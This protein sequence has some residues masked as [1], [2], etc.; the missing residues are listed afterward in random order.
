MKGLIKGSLLRESALRMRWLEELVLERFYLLAS[1]RRFR[2][3]ASAIFRKI[4]RYRIF[5]TQRFN[6]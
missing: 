1:K 3:E 5:A 6:E 2:F 4:L